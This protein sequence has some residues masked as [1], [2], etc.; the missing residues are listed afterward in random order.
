MPI[1]DC[2]ADY[3]ARD[4]YSGSI[5]LKCLADCQT[6]VQEWMQE[7]EKST[8]R[9]SLYCPIPGRYISIPAALGTGQTRVPLPSLC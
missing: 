1:V 8:E 9:E 4:S 6:T 3:T 5:S 2:E 7:L